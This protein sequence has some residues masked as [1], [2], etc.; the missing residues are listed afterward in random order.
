VFAH[1]PFDLE[2]SKAKPWTPPPFQ[3]PV[4]TPTNAPMNH[5]GAAPMNHAGAPSNPG[6]M[7]HAGG[8]GAPSGAPGG[9]PGGFMD[10]T[11]LKLGYAIGSQVYNKLGENYNLSSLKSTNFIKELKLLFKVDHLYVLKKLLLIVFPFKHA[12]FNR[13][14]VEGLVSPKDDLNSPDLYIPTMSFVTFVLLSGIS[15]GLLKKFTPDLLGITSS[16]SLFLLFLEILFIKGGSYFMS[17][18]SSS[19][20]ELTAYTGFKF[21]PLCNLRI[22]QLLTSSKLLHVIVFLYLMIAYGFFTLRTIRYL[23]L[24]DNTSD[25]IGKQA[26]KRRIV[27]L[28]LIAGIQILNTWILL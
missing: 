11:D 23:V 19:I 1:N 20:L 15:F 10:N 13:K 2:M 26:R 6:G 8:P 24:G 9:N 16:T 28:F 4:K 18:N 5:A 25:L 27:F 7:N 14:S 12:S 17:I 22:L 21:V 3:P